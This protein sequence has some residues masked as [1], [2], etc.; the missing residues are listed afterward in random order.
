MEGGRIGEAQQHR[1]AFI[2]RQAKRIV[3]AGIDVAKDD[4]GQ[5]AA[6]HHDGRAD[7]VTAHSAGL[8]YTGRNV[9][10]VRLGAARHAFMGCITSAW[11]MS[12]PTPASGPWRTGAS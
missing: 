4:A 9:V 6:V 1:A 12:P 2:L 10:T 11:G 8:V 7:L 3:V 5:G